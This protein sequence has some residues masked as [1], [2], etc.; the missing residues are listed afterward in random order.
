MYEAAYTIHSLFASGFPCYS[1][2]MVVEE[3]EHP[4]PSD[5]SFS[6]IPLILAL[7]LLPGTY[8]PAW[9]SVGVRRRE[10]EEVH[11]GPARCQLQDP[12]RDFDARAVQGPHTQ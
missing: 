10:L 12:D 11:S 9:A 8:L 2:L 5:P 4:L 6:S 1:G 3:P 7:S